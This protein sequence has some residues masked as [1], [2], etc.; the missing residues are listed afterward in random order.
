MTTTT[1]TSL[2]CGVRRRQEDNLC[3]TRDELVCYLS[4]VAG[5]Y[6]VKVS[7]QRLLYADRPTLWGMICYIMRRCHQQDN[8]A[9]WLHDPEVKEMV[10]QTCPLLAQTLLLDA[11]LPVFKGDVETKWL[12]ASN[13]YEI[14]H[15]QAPSELVFSGVLSADLKPAV[16]H[17]KHPP[18]NLADLQR[19]MHQ[20]KKW[21]VIMNIAVRA[22]PGEHW[23]ALYRD[24][25]NNNNEAAPIE[26][27][28]SLGEK[29]DL[30]RRVGKTIQSLLLNNNNNKS[31][32]MQVATKHQTDD[33]MCGLYACYYIL[34]RAY[35]VPL[36]SFQQNIV[37]HHDMQ[38]FRKASL[39]D[40]ERE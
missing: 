28:D 9:K 35:G 11:L 12:P 16:K 6:N 21:A 17:P 1:T 24:N 2:T 14:V 36:R 7:D 40:I 26:Y 22:R 37:T 13:I 4:A 5:L 31:E 29:C 3:F 10:L 30:R 19:Q 18:I 23:V 8:A 39:L 15:Q 33:Y 34:A 25:N 20:G 38:A 32:L 27:Y